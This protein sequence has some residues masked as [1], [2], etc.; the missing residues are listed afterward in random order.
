MRIKSHGKEGKRMFVKHNYMCLNT[1]TVRLE[2]TFL[3]IKCSLTPSPEIHCFSSGQISMCN[4]HFPESGKASSG[5][6]A[7]ELICNGQITCK[8]SFDKLSE[9]TAYDSP[10][11]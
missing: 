2:N 9:I 3:V 4:T 1:Q 8:I 7:E 10:P 11:Y 6:K 5:G